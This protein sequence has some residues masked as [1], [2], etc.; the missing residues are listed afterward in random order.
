MSYNILIVDDNEYFKAGLK[1]L[2][3]G[4]FLRR[5]DKVFHITM[6]NANPYADIIFWAPSVERSKIPL[7]ILLDK[8]MI[9]IVDEDQSWLSPTVIYRQDD[10]STIYTAFDNSV[11]Q[12]SCF[13]ESLCISDEISPRQNQVLYYI[14]LGISVA[15]IAKY[16]LITEKA[17]SL[18]KRKAML[19]L[20]LSNN[21]ELN[22]WLIKQLRLSHSR[23]INFSSYLARDV[24]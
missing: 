24:C 16:L 10:V 4:Y 21:T 23:H 19:A 22:K 8:R 17:V 9:F 2:I 15:E 18:H 6:E 14:S 13:S 3:D 5:N 11:R 7:E 20:N 12:C 1:R